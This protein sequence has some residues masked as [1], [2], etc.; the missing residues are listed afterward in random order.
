MAKLEL[1]NTITKNH[2]YSGRIFDRKNIYLFFTSEYDSSG[3]LYEKLTQSVRSLSDGIQTENFHQRLTELHSPLE[4][5]NF[6][7]RK[8]SLE[9]RWKSVSV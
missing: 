3:S 8:N 6:T 5:Q 4:F 7:F 1:K 2:N 9:F